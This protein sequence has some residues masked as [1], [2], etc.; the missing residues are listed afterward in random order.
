MNADE[1]KNRFIP[2]VPTIEGQGYSYEMLRDG[3]LRMAKSK[4]VDDV[5]AVIL[6]R[7]R[8]EHYIKQVRDAGARIALIGDGDISGAIST[9]KRDSGV[10]ILRGI[11]GIPKS[12]PRALAADACAC[13]RNRIGCH[14]Q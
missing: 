3:A 11:G 2:Y 14:H 10:D 7:P 8:N 1:I 13:T 9:A 5:T 12:R 4:D 6:N